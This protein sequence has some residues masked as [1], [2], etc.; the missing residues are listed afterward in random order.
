MEVK[1]AFALNQTVTIDAGAITGKV[2]A[3][4]VNRSG[5]KQVHVRY[6]NATQTV[7]TEW[8]EEDQLAAA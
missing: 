2:V 5:I 3:L 6:V 1:F 8:F 4:Y 7:C